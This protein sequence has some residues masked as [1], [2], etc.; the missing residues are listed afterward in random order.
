MTD[1]IILGPI[2]GLLIFML[3]G[4]LISFCWYDHDE[5]QKEKTRNEDQEY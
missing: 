4:V 1:S 2:I 5:D 3:I